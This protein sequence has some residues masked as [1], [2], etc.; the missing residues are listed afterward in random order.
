[1]KGMFVLVFFAFFLFLESL[2]AVAVAAPAIVVNLPSRTLSLFDNGRL[3]KIY[4]VA[5]GSQA[6]PTPQGKFKIFDKE[7]NPTWYPPGKNYSVASGPENP[8]GYRW[9]EFAAS[10]G[11]HGTNHPESIGSV[12]SNG[13]VRMNEKD[14]EELFEQVP[15]GTLVTVI[16]DRVLVKID[17]A[18]RASVCVYPDVYNLGGVTAANVRAQLSQYGLAD[19]VSNEQINHLVDDASGLQVPVASVYYLK[20]ND[21]LLADQAISTEGTV[22]IP[23]DS[24]ATA[25]KRSFIFDEN[26][27]LLKSAN[28]TVPALRRGH[29]IYVTPDNE[30]VL[31]GGKIIINNGKKQVE[32]QVM[33]VFVNG[34][35]VSFDIQQVG[36]ILALPIADVAES[37]GMKLL[38]DDQTGSVIVNGQKVPI[39]VLQERSY[40]QINKINEFFGAYLY[41]NEAAQTIEITYQ[42]P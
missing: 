36:L 16:Y 24:L 18:G 34:K 2:C 15:L 21:T 3:I 22:Y 23:A 8:L 1:M 37:L 25:L 33:Q 28:I 7:V 19:F 6:T 11:I 29:H 9:L 26:N 40:I 31:F 5:I 35:Q 4:P 14:V 27:Q 42:A 32:V 10:Y 13:C 41:Y 38:Y 30:Q 20:V 39:T 17:Q 12:V